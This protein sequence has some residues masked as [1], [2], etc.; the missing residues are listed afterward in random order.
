MRTLSAHERQQYAIARSRERRAAEM[1]SLVAEIDRLVAAV[2]WRQ[3]RPLV[4]DV[5]APVRVTGSRGRWRQRIGKR[6]GRRLLEALCALPAQGRLALGW[7]APDETQL[8]NAEGAVPQYQPPGVPTQTTIQQA[9]KAAT[10]DGSSAVPTVN[11]MIATANSDMAT[12]FALA[13]Q[14]LAQRSCGGASSPTPI[15]SISR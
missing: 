11:G 9:L 14:A 2:G 1:S 13:S 10:S 8:H 3:A 12:A 5:M 6:T 7:I 15:A 4:E